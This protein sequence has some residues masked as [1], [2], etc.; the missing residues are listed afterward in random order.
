[1]GATVG[2]V[3]AAFLLGGA[4]LA[5]FY[6][7]RSRRQR[8]QRN[9]RLSIISEQLGMRFDGPPGALPP[10]LRAPDSYG[11]LASGQGMQTARSASPACSYVNSSP[12]YLPPLPP[13]YPPSPVTSAHDSLSPAEAS[14]K[15]AN[16]FYL[17]PTSRCARCASLSA[18]AEIA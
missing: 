8:A 14:R 2:I 7:V 13:K 6:V 11:S 3:V 18:P 15:H 4:L 1:M 5:L 9:Q 17:A 10:P 12:S 16:S